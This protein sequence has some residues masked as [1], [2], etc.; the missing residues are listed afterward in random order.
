VFALLIL[1]R[2]TK[3]SGDARVIALGGTARVVIVAAIVLLLSAAVRLLLQSAMMSR[4]T[5]ESVGVETILSKTGWGR[6]WIIQVAAAVVILAVS[7]RRGASG[8]WFAAAIAAL[9]MAATPALSG[10]AAA[11]PRWSTLAIGTD[12]LHVIAAAGWLGSLLFVIAVGVPALV[13]VGAESRWIAIASLVEAFSPVA[14]TFAAVV[15]LTGTV[16]AWLRVGSIPALWSSSY[17]RTL[18]VK[19][20]L[21]TGVVATGAYN[22]RR[23]RPSLGTESATMRLRK[24]AAIE[25]TIGALV[26]VV[27]AVLVATPTPADLP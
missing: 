6:A 17:G 24:S 25:L 10:H 22:W 26:V 4:M 27:T 2:A 8:V 9:V 1:P 13:R 23:V 14:L 11:S 15:L 16:S 7:F 18:L 3:V 12:A 21:L 20:S 19:L 5:H